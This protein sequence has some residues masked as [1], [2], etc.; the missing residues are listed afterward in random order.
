VIFEQDERGYPRVRAAPP[1]EVLGWFLEQDVQGNA[2]KCHRLLGLIEE[3]RSGR[4]PHW[5]GTG[6]AHT[7]TLT[8]SG[9]RVENEFVEPLTACDLPL[10]ELAAAV[11]G[12][13]ELIDRVY[14]RRE[15]S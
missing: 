6:N 14:R 12:W 11:R 3:A 1:C 5:Q 8:P 7:L 9:A 4:R 13:L 15:G 10:D 2:A